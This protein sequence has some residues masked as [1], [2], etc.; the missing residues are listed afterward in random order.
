MTVELNK[1]EM[2]NIIFALDMFRTQTIKT[3]P[4][5]EWE[6]GVKRARVRFSMDA[7]TKLRDMYYVAFGNTPESE[8]YEDYKSYESKDSGEVE[9]SKA[10][11]KKDFGTMP[12]I[13]RESFED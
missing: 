8:Y 6:K 2:E 9:L 10:P 3:M 7:I 1:G 11:E 4:A 13:H 12:T 5:G